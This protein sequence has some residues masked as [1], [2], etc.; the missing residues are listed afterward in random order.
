MPARNGTGPI[1]EGRLTGR[2]LGPCGQGLRQTRGFG[3]GLVRNQG[4]GLGLR[5][6]SRPVELNKDEQK[7]IL[8]EELE[9]LES[10]RKA[11]EDKLRELE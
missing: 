8:Q 9:A 6:D 5:R 3:R 2:G 11:V 1:G 10:D 4:T 7:K